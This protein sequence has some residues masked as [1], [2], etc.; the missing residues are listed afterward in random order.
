MLEKQYRLPATTRLKNY[1]LFDSQAFS[2]K[3]AKNNLKTSRFGFVI[4]KKTD[5]RATT[6]NRIR[7]VFRSCIEEMFSEIKTGH[8]MLFFL[9][10]GILEIKRKELYNQ[11]YDF[12]KEKDLII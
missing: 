3:I 10:S 2:L 5:K 11:V 1:D 8:D 12:L 9:K 7:R 6:R 4:G